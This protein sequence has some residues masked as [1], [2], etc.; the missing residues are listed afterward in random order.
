MTTTT[1]TKVLVVISYNIQHQFLKHHIAILHPIE[2]IPQLIDIYIIQN[3]MESEADIVIVDLIYII[4]IGYI[5]WY[6]LINIVMLQA[7]VM[8]IVV[9]WYSIFSKRKGINKFDNL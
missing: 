9:S 8:F 7:C 1:R 3:V 4:C 6:D 2:Y 5:N